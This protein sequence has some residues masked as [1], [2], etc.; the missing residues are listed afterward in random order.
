MN[1]ISNQT[2]KNYL[3]SSKDKNLFKEVYISENFDECKINIELPSIEDFL[4]NINSNNYKD[5][6]STIFSFIDNSD[7]IKININ[8]SIET[9]ETFN[10]LEEISKYRYQFDRSNKEGILEIIMHK[11]SHEY[12]TIYFMDSFIEFL[13]KTANISFIFELFEK[14]NKK[15]KVLSE[16][17]FYVKTNNFYF[18]SAQ[19]YDSL[20]IIENNNE[21]KLKKINENCHFGNAASIKFLPE[22]FYYKFNDS[23]S[24]Q[25]FK[26]LFE[27]L[28]MV[29]LLRVFADVSEFNDNKLIYKMFGYKTIQH[30]YDLMSIKTNFLNDYYQS[31]SDLFFDNSNFID[32]IGLAR[33]VISLHT[34]NQDFTNIK[35]D[36]YS[37]IKS[38]YNIYLKENIKKYIDLKNKITDK[39][40]AIS[41]SFDNLVDEFSKSFKS[42]FYTLSTI[43]LSLILLK[44]IKGNTS[45][46]PIF[47]FEVYLFLIAVLF[48]MYLFKKYILFELSQK[49]S[50]LF[51]QY[52]QLKNQYISLL[53]KSDLDELLMY[54]NF[55]EKNDTYIT[56]QTKQYSKYWNRTLFVYFIVFTFLTI[57]V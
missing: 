57:Y 33:N 27:R 29:L 3:Y 2:L 24:N 9:L 11:N 5:L 50:R 37:S 26:N 21:E 12:T 22:D 20:V 6:F 13:N 52:E 51:E 15:F 19:N 43:F 42:S 4:T 41:N 7:T 40:F 18:A 54:N 8:D 1:S 45:H 23:F 36:I 47:T 48:A 44:L 39:L 28:S 34:V 17:N 31:Y 55:K 53:D 35:G 30:Q 14:H 38:N 56:E 46:I 49:K 16:Q 10:S 25:N 32:K